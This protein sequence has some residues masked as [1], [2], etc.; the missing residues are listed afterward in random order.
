MESQKSVAD[1]AF[2]TLW[3][4]PMSARPLP[5]EAAR[6]ILHR[7]LAPLQVGWEHRPEAAAFPDELVL[8][9]RSSG[10]IPRGG[11]FQ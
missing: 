11:V 2:L 10:V 5:P 4:R 9:F 3:T 7:K 6:C 1:R 8:S